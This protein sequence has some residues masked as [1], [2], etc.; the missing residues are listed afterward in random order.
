[1]AMVFSELR[2][3]P[4]TGELADHYRRKYE[5]ER[6]AE[7]KRR[8]ER[9]QRVEADHAK[10]LARRTAN[11]LDHAARSKE[12]CSKRERAIKALEAMSAV[13]R[14]IAVAEDRFSLPIEAIPFS[15]LESHESVILALSPA[16]RKKLIDRIDR[17]RGQ[18]GA[19]RRALEA[20]QS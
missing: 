9:K 16:V 20:H 15:L 6:A 2:R 4:P 8:S 13:D 14:L 7:L 18:Y 10:V 12:S 1:M 17:R 5:Q 3:L 19:F 11:A